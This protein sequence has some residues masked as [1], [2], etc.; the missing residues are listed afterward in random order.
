MSTIAAEKKDTT[1]I[2]YCTSNERYQKFGSTSGC[3]GATAPNS[4]SW[5]PQASHL[6]KMLTSDMTLGLC[7][8]RAT[9]Q[10]AVLAVIFVPIEVIA[11]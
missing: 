11:V 3:F 9:L 10:G 2:E 7:S 6:H 1:K 5:S 8:N 4:R